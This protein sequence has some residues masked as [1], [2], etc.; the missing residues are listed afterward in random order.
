MKTSRACLLTV[1]V[2]AGA[3]VPATRAAAD[4]DLHTQQH[5]L[6]PTGGAPLVRGTVVAAHAEGPVVHGHDRVL[7]VGAEPS[8]TY[9]IRLAL[10]VD[11]LLGLPTC[12]HAAPDGP[13]DVGEVRTN[14]R[15]NGSATSTF[16]ASAVP[17]FPDG[18]DVLPVNA[19]WTLVD[20]HGA[21]V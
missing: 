10:Y 18:V 5:V 7:L 4:A 14:A 21:V 2:V 15:G 16:P 20:Q 11:G 9:G 19:E 8:T 12:Q 6:L 1:A 3:L 17:A 13:F